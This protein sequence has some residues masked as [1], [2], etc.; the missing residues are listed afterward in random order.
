METNDRAIAYGILRLTLGINILLH[1]V[2][3]FPVWGAFATGVVRQFHGILPAPL[4]APY[5]YA[6]PA[7]EAVTG[8]LLVVGLFQRPALIAGALFMAS[9]TFGTALRGEHDV[10]AEQ[11]GYE[12]TY[13][14]LI[15]TASWDRFSADALLARRTVA[16]FARRER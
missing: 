13:A 2:Q 8:A 6:L 3:R 14:V 16:T 9:L 1:G 11:L 12:L 15:A 5:A 10:L 4:V 7:V